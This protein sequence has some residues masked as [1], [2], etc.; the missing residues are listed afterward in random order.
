MRGWVQ[1]GFFVGGMWVVTWVFWLSGA[2]T[3]MTFA[4]ALVGCTG[5]ALMLGCGL[6]AWEQ[7]PSD[8]AR[9]TGQGEGA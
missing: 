2:H 9:T 4:A 8:Q 1:T 5:M 6:H 7:A 3:P